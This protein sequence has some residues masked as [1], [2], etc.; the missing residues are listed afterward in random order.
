MSATTLQLASPGGHGPMG[1]MQVTQLPQHLQSAAT[2]SAFP[3]AVTPVPQ[4]PAFYPPMLYWYPSPP[5]TP[6]PATYYA[7]HPGPCSIIM[8]GLPYNVTIQDVVNYFQGFPEVG[9]RCSQESR[10]PW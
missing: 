9:S 6:H 2:T 5:V 4:R 8:R 3:P 7:P 10:C 1:T